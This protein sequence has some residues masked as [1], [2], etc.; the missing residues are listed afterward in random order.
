MPQRT[1]ESLNK[2]MAQPS[3]CNLG[4]S[5]TLFNEACL[6][7]YANVLPLQLVRS[8]RRRPLNPTAEKL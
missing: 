4:D 6:T 1:E 8:L 2:Q 7:D 3:P 5:T